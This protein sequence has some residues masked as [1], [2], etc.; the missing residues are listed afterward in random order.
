MSEIKPY[1]TAHWD[2]KAEVEVMFDKIS[3]KY[4]F[5]NRLLSLGI[6]RSWRKKALECLIPYHPKV[7]LDMATGTGDL[8]FMADKILKPDTIIGVDLSAGMLN[9]AHKRLTENAKELNSSI[10][11]LKGDAE[12]ILFE[13]NTFDAVTVAFGVRNF[14]DLQTG[15][16]ELNRVLKPGAPVMVLEFTKPRI[17]PFRQLFDIYFRHVL[18]LIGSWTSGDKRAYKYLYESVQAFPDFERFNAELIKAGFEKP[19]Y[20]SLSAGICAIYLAYKG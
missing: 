5:L 2:K 7:I 17:F 10:E 18:P 4:D 9:I 6:D 15:L 13:A 8:A 12:K 11:F 20:Q 19:V 1:K 3:G 14:A 16:K